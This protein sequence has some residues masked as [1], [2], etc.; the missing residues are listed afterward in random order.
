M[1]GQGPSSYAAG[2]CGRGGGGGGRAI[3]LKQARGG[4]PVAALPP[5]GWARLALVTTAALARRC[6]HVAHRQLEACPALCAG[7]QRRAASA[8]P[9]WRPSPRRPRPPPSPR[10][11]RTASRLR[12]RGQGAEGEGRQASR[13]DGWV[14]GWDPGCSRMLGL[15]AAAQTLPNRGTQAP[16][17]AAPVRQRKGHPAAR[18]CLTR[19]RGP[20][21]CAGPGSQTSC[22]TAHP[23]SA[24]RSAAAQ[25]GG[26]GRKPG[27][28]GR[29]SWAVGPATVASPRRQR[30]RPRAAGACRA[31]QRSCAPTLGVMRL[32]AS[33]ARSALLQGRG[34]EERRASRCGSGGGGRR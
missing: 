32:S 26:A 18:S 1:R 17:E 9:A 4:W 6:P 28:A 23:P 13:V 19:R 31:L 21:L 20:H 24:R 12:G 16:S 15:A 10:R 25:R 8:H 7:G 30:V 29:G 3:S 27:G 5:G 34:R 11:S 33:K 14:G 22:P 2:T